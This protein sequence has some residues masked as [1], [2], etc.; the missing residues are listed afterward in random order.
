[1]LQLEVM[2]QLFIYI[3]FNWV[4]DSMATDF[5]VNVSAEQMAM[6]CYIK[7]TVIAKVMLLK[8]LD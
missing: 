7:S 5:E 3:C 4:H 8:W 1:M 6:H 2:I